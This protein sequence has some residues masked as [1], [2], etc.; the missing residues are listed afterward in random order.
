VGIDTTT[1]E[2]SVKCWY[3]VCF[4]V[5]PSSSSTILCTQPT[6]TTLFPVLS[7]LTGS[8]LSFE[9]L[10]LERRAHWRGRRRASGSITVRGG[11]RPCALNLRN[12]GGAGRSLSHRFGSGVQETEIP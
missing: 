10:T 5:V 3:P 7:K 9:D 8:V 2:L 12:D 11:I 6:S 1:L 4:L